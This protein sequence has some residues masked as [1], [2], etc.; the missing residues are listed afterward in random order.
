MDV[1][2]VPLAWHAGC[3]KSDTPKLAKTRKPPKLQLFEITLK[4]WRAS[5]NGEIRN[6]SRLDT[7]DHVL[8]VLG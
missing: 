6:Y 3:T 1:S 5:K 8:E 2:V 4:P 7:Q